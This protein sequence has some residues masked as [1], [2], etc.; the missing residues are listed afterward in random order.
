MDIAPFDFNVSVSAIKPYFYYCKRCT[1]KIVKFIFISGVYR[2]ILLSYSPQKKKEIC[3]DLYPSNTSTRTADEQAQQEDQHPLFKGTIVAIGESEIIKE[4][5][6]FTCLST[7]KSSIL[8]SAFRP[9]FMYA[10]SEAAKN[11]KTNVIIKNYIAMSPEYVQLDQKQLEDQYVNVR[12]NLS[13]SK[14]SNIILQSL[15]LH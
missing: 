11:D 14:S 15:I 7:E 2:G 13:K 9:G 12:R 5:I 4:D 1:K 10:S 3:D 8:S 6:F